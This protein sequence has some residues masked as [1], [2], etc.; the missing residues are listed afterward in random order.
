MLPSKTRRAMVIR[1]EISHDKEKDDSLPLAT[2]ETDHCRVK[3]LK[4]KLLLSTIGKLI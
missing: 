4:A 2:N 3:I 1:T